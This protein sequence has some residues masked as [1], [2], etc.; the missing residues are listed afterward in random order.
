MFKN[1]QFVELPYEEPIEI[2]SFGD[3]IYMEDYIYKNSL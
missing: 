2:E 3:E 1:I